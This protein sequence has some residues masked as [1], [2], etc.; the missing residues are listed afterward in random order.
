[1]ATTPTNSPPAG[2][3]QW[4]AG[5]LR[6]AAYLQLALALVFAIASVISW[7]EYRKSG[8]PT[9]GEKTEKKAD[10]LE[11]MLKKSKEKDKEKD[12][13]K[14]V[15][16]PRDPEKKLIGLWTGKVTLLFLLGALWA[17]ASNADPNRSI[18]VRKIIA[19]I[20]TS[21]GL[22][23]VTLGVVVLYGSQPGLVKWLDSGEAE[24]GRQTIIGL[25]IVLTSLGLIFLS[26]LPARAEERNN[27]T[28]RRLAYSGNNLILGLLLLLVLGVGNV[29]VAMNLPEKLDATASKFYTL[30]KKSVD[31][32]GSVQ[33]TV[34]LYLIAST[35]QDAN[36]YLDL[37]ALLKNC[38]QVNANVKSH[39]LVPGPNT[40]EI[41]AL[42][43]RFKMPNNE[44]AEGI[45]VTVGENEQKKS[46]IPLADITGFNE[47]DKAFTFEGENKLMTELS[48]LTSTGGDPV[49]YF[50]QGN[51]E[52]NPFEPDAGPKSRTASKLRQALADKKFQLK[53]L[54]YEVGKP[55]EVPPDATAVLVLAPRRPL[56][57]E[58]AMPLHNYVLPVDA[59]AKAPHESPVKPPAKA[60]RLIIVLPPVKEATGNR[61]AAAGLENLLVD[62]GLSPLLSVVMT[63]PPPG[64]TRSLPLNVTR[65]LGT[66]R[67]LGADHPLA[68]LLVED[69]LLEN[70]RAFEVVP[71]RNKNLRVTP[72]I[73]TDPAEPTWLEP[74]FNVDGKSIA[75]ALF[76]RS[77][78]PATRQL[79]KEKNLAQRAD[80]LALVVSEMSAPADPMRPPNPADAKPRMVVF[81]SDSVI[82]DEFFAKVNDEI[83]DSHLA[84]VGGAIEW[85]R[86]RPTSIGIEPRSHPV[87]ILNP[88]KVDDWR[89][90]FAPLVWSLAGIMGLGLVVWVLRRS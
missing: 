90:F 70:A 8:T 24:E 23:S 86:E 27:T 89:L 29:M 14:A 66:D 9:D 16:L 73:V 38:Q 35:K 75:Q 52:F 68:R 74:N 88:N 58:V 3:V 39:F 5:D 28:L 69:Y 25:L 43:E 18:T 4:L 54:P 76:D 60:G 67:G 40:P 33:E 22:V 55:F 45:L 15:E 44:R 21:V 30:D 26:I 17:A 2:M 63:A 34:N 13:E 78:I 41:A 42:H 77:N 79:Q 48:F 20:G 36:M 10:D 56:P 12:P 71:P 81:G 59:R 87:F 46:F 31:F 50:T 85:L 72:I 80:P 83:R 57:M 53:P 49:L 62:A 65:A 84:L 61:V 47:R 82:S 11:E 32:L 37:E 7:V 51:G 6:R 64:R 19:V 1:M